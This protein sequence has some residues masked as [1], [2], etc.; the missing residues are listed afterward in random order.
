MSLMHLRT[1]E[2]VPVQRGSS[3]THAAQGAQASAIKASAV[4]QLH[5]SQRDISGFPMPLCC[6]LRSDEVYTLL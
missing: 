3:W 4:L 5:H 2:A 6:P 1:A